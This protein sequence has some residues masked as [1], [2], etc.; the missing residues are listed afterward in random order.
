[1]QR[2]NILV[3][4]AGP[5]GSVAALAAARLGHTVTLGEALERI[6]ETRRASTTQPPTLEILAELGLIDE[7]IRVGLVAR[8]FEFW[9]RPALERIAVF[10]F[11]RLRGE[12]DFPFVVQTEQHK[13]ANMALERLRAMPNAEVF[14]GTA[15]SALHQH[16]N[17]VKVVAGERQFTAEYVIGADGGGRPGRKLLRIEVGGATRR[18]RAP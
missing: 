16:E 9:D 17:E 1:M 6:D 4:G 11:E 3:V 5:V 2:R 7:Y 15:V 14:L 18:A 13:L 12:T 8:T 10:D